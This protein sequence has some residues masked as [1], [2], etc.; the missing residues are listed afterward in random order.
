MAS[1]WV[2]TNAV[3]PGR[4]PNLVTAL[5]GDARIRA[6]T[7]AFAGDANTRRWEQGFVFSPFG[8]PDD[9]DLQ[10]P[11]C[12]MSATIGT[13]EFPSD[14]PGL[15][16]AMFHRSRCSTFGDP[17]RV[18]QAA[19]QMLR[20]TT[21][22]KLEAEFWT[23]TRTKATGRTGQYLTDANVTQVEGGT[24]LPLVQGFGILQ[25]EIGVVAQGQ[26][27]F[28]HMTPM[29]AT[30]LLSQDVITRNVDGLLL[31]GMG[32][33]VVAGTGY[34][35]SSPT[36][37]VDSTQDTAWVYA[38]LSPDMRLSDITTTTPRTIESVDPVNNVQFATA[39]RLGAVSFDPC[40]QL[41]A[42]LALC[43]IFCQAG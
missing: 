18:Q 4:W 14:V 8:C 27:A 32:N 39:M 23:G 40:L 30:L 1:Q 25:N 3:L 16:W 11:T 26:R 9:N 21:S 34:D 19:E 41:G 35:G 43:E 22:H 38:T 42:N 15:A 13:T 37:V 10:D 12:G 6:F 33:V 20:A 31:D 28:I 2:P 5:G 24:A 29:T 7:D 17:D 36:D